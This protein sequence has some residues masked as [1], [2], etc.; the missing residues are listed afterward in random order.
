MLPRYYF[1]MD[2]GERRTRDDIGLD[3]AR[4]AD[5]EREVGMM[6][7]NLG[8]ALVLEGQPRIINAAV[9]DEQ[10]E[11]V[12]ESSIVLSIESCGK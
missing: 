5:V 2:D 9:R 4:R 1:D 12:C 11:T 7:Q 6:L 3:L 10:G 8:M